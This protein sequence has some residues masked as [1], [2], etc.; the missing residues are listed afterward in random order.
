MNGNV[1]LHNSKDLIK[2]YIKLEQDKYVIV[3]ND[4]EDKLNKKFKW[5]N[6]NFIKIDKFL[7]HIN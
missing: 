5:I 1:I 2:N 7:F 4:V 3:V 6:Y